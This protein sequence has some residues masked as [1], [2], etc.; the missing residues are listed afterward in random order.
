VA[1]VE[2][3]GDEELADST[4][5]SKDGESH[6]EF[7][8]VDGLTDAEGGCGAGDLDANLLED[9]ETID[10]EPDLGDLVVLESV[11]DDAVLGDRLVAWWKAG[12]GTGVDRGHSPVS[13]G[14]VVVGDDAVDGE[15]LI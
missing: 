9:A 13:C 2:G 14:L 7:S 8:V 10:L 15:V 11:K 12:E 1:L 3:H 6:V 5:G 4:G